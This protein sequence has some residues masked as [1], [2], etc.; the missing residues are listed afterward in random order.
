ML[1][2]LHGLLILWVVAMAG[3]VGIRGV[4]ERY[5]RGIKGVRRVVVTW[6]VCIFLEF[7]KSGQVVRRHDIGAYT[8]LRNI[9]L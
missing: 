4:V 5:G 7:R 3:D 6:C 1:E 8:R 9:T 2:G